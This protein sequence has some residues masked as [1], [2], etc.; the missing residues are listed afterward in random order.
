[1]RILGAG[2]GAVLLVLT[3]VWVLAQPPSQAPTE[4]GEAARRAELNAAWQSGQAAAR[5]GPTQVSLIDQGGLSLSDRHLFIPKIEGTRI[6]RALGNTVN[7]QNFVGLVVGTR[8]T[9]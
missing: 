6:L 9:D 2:L 4:S 3:P 7:E 8:Q 5:K 1:M